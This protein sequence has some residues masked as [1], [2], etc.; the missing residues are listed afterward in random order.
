MS[1]KISSLPHSNF[2]FI[3]LL[4]HKENRYSSLPLEL[5]TDM[6]LAKRVLKNEKVVNV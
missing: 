1:T 3:C 4:I 2:I 6:I 5:R